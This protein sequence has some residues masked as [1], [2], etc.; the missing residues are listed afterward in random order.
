MMLVSL[1]QASENLRRDTSADDA[2]LTLKIHAASG[3]VLNY[4]GEAA[5]LFL[6]TSGEVLLDSNDDPVGVPEVVQM[7]V[8][9]LVAVLYRDRDASDQFKDGLLPPVVVSLLYPLRTPVLS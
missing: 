6:D 4:L 1:E 5:E 2:D 7:A 3:A 8:L 9:Y